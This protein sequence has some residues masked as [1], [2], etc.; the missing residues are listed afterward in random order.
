MMRESKAE[1]L[2]EKKEE[3]KKEKTPWKPVIKEGGWRERA[4][5]REDSWRKPEAK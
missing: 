3:E 4:L 5:Q 2:I 1:E